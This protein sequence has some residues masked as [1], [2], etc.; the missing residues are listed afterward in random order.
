MPELLMF[1][2]VCFD[3]CQ[4]RVRFIDSHLLSAYNNSEPRRAVFTEEF[5][6]D[7]CLRLATVA[8]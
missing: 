7:E 3:E 4:Y 8:T 1:I 6:V 2:Q 5:T